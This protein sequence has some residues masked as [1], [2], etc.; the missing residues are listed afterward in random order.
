MRQIRKR[1]K[2][3][4]IPPNSSLMKSSEFRE[5]Q[6]NKP[7]LLLPSP[8]EYIPLPR[9]WEDFQ[10]VHEQYREHPIWDLC[11]PQEYYQ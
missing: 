2:L 4:Q 9:T 6:T 11:F 10:A 5:R 8:E 1:L 3:R 7:Q